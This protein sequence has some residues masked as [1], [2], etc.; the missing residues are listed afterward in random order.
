M[1]YKIID[2]GTIA[3]FILNVIY[4]FDI[5]NIYMVIISFKKKLLLLFLR[6]LFYS[7]CFTIY[8]NIRK[9]SRF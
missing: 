7:N 6:D 9:H 5:N 3:I 4:L 1:Y 8:A 2:I